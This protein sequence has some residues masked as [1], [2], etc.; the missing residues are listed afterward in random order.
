M[1]TALFNRSGGR[2]TLTPA[3]LILQD[4]ATRLKLLAD[5]AAQAVAAS[6]GTELDELRVGASQTIGQYLLP[7]LLARFL[8][9]HPGLPIQGLSGNTEEVLLALTEHRIDLA[10][11]EGPTLRADVKAEPFMQD[12][13][14]LVVPPAHPWVNRPVSPAELATEPLVTREVGSGSRRVVEAALEAIGL[15][16]PDLHI[17]LTLD[18]TE[19]LLSAVEAGLGVAFVS[20]WAVRNQL[21]LGTL[22]VAH[23][24]GLAIARTFSAAHRAGP[25]PAGSAGAFLR[26]LH[27]NADGLSPRPTGNPRKL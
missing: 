26:F 25:P 23:V 5:E 20:R 16:T 3:G 11:I 4:F 8:H 9:T 10:L 17:T 12:H 14:I 1:G 22:R 7:N 21:T 13:M 6:T 27:Q 19:G 24:T 15:Q 18:S 2:V